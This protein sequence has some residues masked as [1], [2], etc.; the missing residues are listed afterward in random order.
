ML[1]DAFVE[2][3]TGHLA[4]TQPLEVIEL[5]RYMASLMKASAHHYYVAFV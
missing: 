3:L 2:L 5:G 1:L 4:E